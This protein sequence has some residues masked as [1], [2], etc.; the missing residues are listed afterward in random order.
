MEAMSFESQK[1]YSL[2]IHHKYWQILVNNRIICRLGH[3]NHRSD[4]ELFLPAVE[5]Y[6]LVNKTYLFAIEIHLS[7]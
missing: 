5:N 4:D 7:D 1:P 2:E 3:K 6:R